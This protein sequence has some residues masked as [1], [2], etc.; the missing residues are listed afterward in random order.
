[1]VEVSNSTIG[2]LKQVSRAMGAE[3]KRTLNR[4]SVTGW[5]RWSQSAAAAVSSKFLYT[6]TVVDS[7]RSHPQTTEA[8]SKW[9]FGTQ[10]LSLH[11][12]CAP[13]LRRWPHC[14]TASQVMVPH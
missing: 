7:H 6:A 12:F 11:A 13:S 9:T 8:Q 4:L 10:T 1:M 14:L 2:K 3:G 5:A